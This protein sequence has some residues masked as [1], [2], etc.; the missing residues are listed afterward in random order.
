MSSHVDAS[1]ARMA[2]GKLPAGTSHGE[3]IGPQDVYLPRSHLKAVEPD[4]LL[5]TGMRGA[6]KTDLDAP[7]R[8]T[9]ATAPP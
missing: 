2:L 5:V 3:R 1:I 8:P 7:A 6:G 9:T 4:V